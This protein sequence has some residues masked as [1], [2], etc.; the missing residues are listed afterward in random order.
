MDAELFGQLTAANIVEQQS[1]ENQQIQKNIAHVNETWEQKE[2]NN[3][4]K[5]KNEQIEKQ[6]N[7]LAGRANKAE[8]ELQETREK[9]TIAEQALV[10][11]SL[12]TDEAFQELMMEFYAASPNKED[13]VKN[14]LAKLK[15]RTKQIIE[16]KRNIPIKPELRHIKSYCDYA[17]DDNKIFQLTPEDLERLIDIHN[18]LVFWKNQKIDYFPEVLLSSSLMLKHKRLNPRN[19]KSYCEYAY[20]DNKISKLTSEDLERLI[21]LHNRLVFWKN[22]KL[23]E[24]HNV[25]ISNSLFLNKK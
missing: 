24:Y 7:I 17:Y 5:N 14:D 18:R 8:N 19:I 25:S 15:Y 1:K 21:D 13:R 12:A 3:A 4:L 11:H 22:Q 23:D 2:K 10:A 16:N 20:D 9:L 6:N